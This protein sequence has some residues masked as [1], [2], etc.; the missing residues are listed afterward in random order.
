MWCPSCVPGSL[1]DTSHVL[2]LPTQIHWTV[3]RDRSGD[4]RIPVTDEEAEGQRFGM[5]PMVTVSECVAGIRSQSDP[6]L[7]VT[8]TGS[9][10]CALFIGPHFLPGRRP[11]FGDT[12]IS[13]DGHSASSPVLPH[14]RAFFKES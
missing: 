13:V 10:T 7:T 3:G 11:A 4:G 14:G 12:E 9:E 6:S 2:S 5:E 1:L 8:L